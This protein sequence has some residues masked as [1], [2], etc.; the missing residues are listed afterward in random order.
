MQVVWQ[1]CEEGGGE[2]YTGL[3]WGSVCYIKIKKGKED[4]CKRVMKRGKERDIKRK[5]QR[6]REQGKGYI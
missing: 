3:Q 2:G 4:G 5:R 1:R 6:E